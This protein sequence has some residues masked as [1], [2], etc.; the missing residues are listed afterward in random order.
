MP[1][2]KNCEKKFPCKVVIDGK[3]CNS[4]RRK[5]C[6]DCNPIGGRNFWGESKVNK[7]KTNKRC[8]ICESCNRE[9]NQATNGKFCVTCKSRKYRHAKKEKG[10]ALL[11]GKCE[12]CGYSKC[13]QALE[14][15]HKESSEKELTLASSWTLPWETLEK[16]ILKC[17]LLCCR[18]HVEHHYS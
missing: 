2:C 9:V 18:C 14:F 3:T 6:Y 13:K 4:P 17:S 5:Y 10:I 16:E 8:F 7:N 1:T 15:H 11:G 12:K